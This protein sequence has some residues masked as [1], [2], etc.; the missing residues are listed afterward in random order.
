MELARLRPRHYRIAFDG[1][2]EEI[3]AVLLAIGNIPSY[4]GAMRICPDADPTDGKLDVVWA[5]PISRTTLMRIKPKVYAGTHVQHPKVR[6]RRVTSISI[7][8]PGIVCY[9]DG[10]RV[11]AL[12][13]RHRRT[14]GVKP[15]QR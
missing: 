14:G 4:G 7:D 11:S 13:S 15:L 10:E 1:Q 3:D 6:Q 5:E 2:P 9:A 12:R 8:A